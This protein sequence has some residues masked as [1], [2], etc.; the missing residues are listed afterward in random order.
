MEHGELEN[1][2]A[3]LQG[4]VLGLQ[5]A[6]RALICSH[7]DP[8]AALAQIGLC[9]EDM[10]ASGLASNTTTDA[11]LLGLTKSPNFLQPTA[12]QLDRARSR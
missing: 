10:I 9:H 4:Q 8:D 12:E 11:L 2:L 1:R 5:A 3:Y 6:V 7:H